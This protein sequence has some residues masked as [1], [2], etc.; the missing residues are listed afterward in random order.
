M[1]TYVTEGELDLHQQKEL[2][3]LADLER[4]ETTNETNWI[5]AREESIRNHFKVEKQVNS[6]GE[7]C[8]L[9]IVVCKKG[10]P[11]P[12]E[13]DQAFTSPDLALKAVTA[14]LNQQK[15]NIHND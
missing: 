5:A 15:E 10:K 4:S 3:G 9:Y 11:L 1:K 12:R 6:E 2:D 7:W 14:Y 8:G 13:L